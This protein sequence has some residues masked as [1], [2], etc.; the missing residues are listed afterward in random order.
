MA[1]LPSVFDAT[2]EIDD[3]FAAMPVGWYTAT[4]KES[5]IAENSKKNGKFLKLGFVVNGGQYNDKKLYTYLNI[6]NPSDVAEAIAKKDMQAICKAL[7]LQGI[8]DSN[9][10]HG[11]PMKIKLKIQAA[12]EKYG[13]SNV[14]THYA[15]MDTD[16]EDD[17]DDESPF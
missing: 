9:E 10:L 16:V 7:D 6:K 1:E 8:K 11:Q 12:T 15:S 13:E 17:N 2:E 3:P 5:E 14:I 4:I